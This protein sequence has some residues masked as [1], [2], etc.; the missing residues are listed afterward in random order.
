MEELKPCPFCGDYPTI[1]AMRDIVEYSWYVSCDNMQCLVR[2]ITD[3]TIKT[4]Q[5]AIDAWNRRA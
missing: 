2:P 5:Q 3:I 4:K 1:D